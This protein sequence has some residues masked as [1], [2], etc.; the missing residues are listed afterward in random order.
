[1]PTPTT[2]KRTDTHSRSQL[3]SPPFPLTQSSPILPVS[4]AHIPTHT[5]THNQCR[6]EYTGVAYALA[7]DIHPKTERCCVLAPRRDGDVG[8]KP[9][10]GAH[11]REPIVLAG[12]THDS[13]FAIVRVRMGMLY[14]TRRTLQQRLSQCRQHPSSGEDAARTWTQTRGGQPQSTAVDCTAGIAISRRSHCRST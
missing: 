8:G 6:G 7:D 5:E 10:G 13:T 14:R 4:C 12:S 9:E 2:R 1:V 3:A 11:Q